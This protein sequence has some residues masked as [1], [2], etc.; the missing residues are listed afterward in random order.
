MAFVH[1]H[2][3]DTGWV[4][5]HIRPPTDA[6]DG[7]LRLPLPAEEDGEPDDSEPDDSEPNAEITR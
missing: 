5:A 3:R 1:G 2:A 6:E 4:V 7:Q